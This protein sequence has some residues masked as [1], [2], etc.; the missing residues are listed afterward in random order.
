MCGTPEYAPP[1]VFLGRQ[2]MGP[3]FDMWSAGV[4]LYAMATGYFPLSNIFD[5]KYYAQ[6]RFLTFLMSVHLV[7]IF[8]FLVFLCGFIEAKF[9]S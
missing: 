3:P 7:C 8:L 4:I 5:W 2:Y 9:F 1:E 6:R